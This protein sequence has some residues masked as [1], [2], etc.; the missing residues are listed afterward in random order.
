MSK[1]YYVLF[2]NHTDG[3]ALYEYLRNRSHQ[4]RIAPVPREASSC[5]GMSLLVN[6][7]D[8]GKVRVAIDES[9]IKIDH[10]AELE[11]QIDPKRDRYC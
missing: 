3:M 9:E 5:C 4:V 6:P 8:I 10:I 7:E 2:Y 11:N 1:S